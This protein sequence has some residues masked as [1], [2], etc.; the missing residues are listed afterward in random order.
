[1]G[2]G[3]SAS[4]DSFPDSSVGKESSCNAGDL[5]LIP[6]LGRSPGEGKATHSNILAWRIPWTTIH[7]V[8]KSQ[9]RL[10]DFHFHFQAPCCV[11]TLTASSGWVPWMPLAQSTAWVPDAESLCPS[12]WLRGCVPFI[13]VSTPSA[14]PLLCFLLHAT[15][16]LGLGLLP[17]RKRLSR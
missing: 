15:V 1:M 2:L 3:S 13:H 12:P 10:N 17:S 14:L 9:T 5:G 11:S 7:G 4:L 6:G 8:T 16:I